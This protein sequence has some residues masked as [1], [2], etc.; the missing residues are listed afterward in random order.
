VFYSLALFTPTIIKELGFTNANANLLSVPP[1]VLGFITSVLVAI[2]SDRLF[3]RGVFIIGGLLMVIIG[4]VILITNVSVGVKY[5]TSYVQSFHSIPGVLFT[6]IS[7]AIFLCVGGV[8]PC[9]ATTTTFIGNKFVQY[10]L[11][12]LL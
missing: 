8:S 7:V 9:G 1:Y 3:R 10:L 2:A 6:G 5:C 4:Y 11:C 12:G